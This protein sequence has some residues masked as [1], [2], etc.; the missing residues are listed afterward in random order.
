MTLVC[1]R[2]ILSVS[3]LVLLFLSVVPTAQDSGT[4]DLRRVPT[5]PS[6]YQWSSSTGPTLPMTAGTTTTGRV[7]LE[8]RA[9]LTYLWPILREASGLY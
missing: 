1:R 9:P 6:G 3:A 8:Q 5:T 2:S 7:V 4:A